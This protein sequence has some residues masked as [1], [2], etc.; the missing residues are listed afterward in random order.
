MRPF[1]I[2]RF[3]LPAL[4]VASAAAAQT[5]P[6]RDPVDDATM[7]IGPFGLTPVIIIRDVGRDNNVF[8]EST[9]PKSD[10]TATLTPKLDVLVHPGP[11]LLT[12]STTSDYIYYQKYASERGT[13]IGSTVRADFTFGPVRPYASASGGNSKD[14]VNREIDARARHRDRAYS[15]GVRVRIY[16]GVFASAG[17]RQTSILFDEDA[18]F[19]GENLAEA[20]D[21]QLNAVEGSIGVALTPL[22]SV[23]LNVSKERERFDLSPG[24]DSDTLRIMP[25]VTFS[26]LAMLNGSAA[27]G[28]RR[29]EPL[30]PAVPDYRGFIANLTLGTTIRE[31]HRIE[32]VF[33]RDVQYSYEQ[34]AVYYVETGIQGIW[35]WQVVGPIDLR[36]SGSRSRLHYQSASL[37][38]SNDEDIASS[39]GAGVSWRLRPTL[40]VGLN[41]DW[42][43]RDSE[44]GSDRA[45]DNRRIYAGVTWGKQ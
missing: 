20:L 42:R 36:L 40:R 4:L 30:S 11:L 26:P 29:F 17:A 34:D 9:N 41:G 5:S 15:G 18:V 19:R 12:V 32:T 31:R 6:P 28:Y 10:F 13:N 23:S 44:R 7:R 33:A 39:Y 2:V 35:T 27:F 21:E 8:N 16:E 43:G 37:D 25:T 3:L 14:R 24:R 1:A 38:D 22:T 45:Y